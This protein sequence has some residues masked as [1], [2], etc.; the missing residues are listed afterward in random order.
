MTDGGNTMASAADFQI[1]AVEA[2]GFR[3]VAVMF[4]GAG[5]SAG[6]AHERTLSSLTHD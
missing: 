1:S 2:A 3:P 4:L 6:Q 5:N